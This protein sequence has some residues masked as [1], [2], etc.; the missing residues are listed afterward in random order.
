MLIQARINEDRMFNLCSWSA[1]AF[2]ADPML[3][4]QTDDLQLVK[5]LF[6][7]INKIEI[8]V[9]GN[10]AG[11]YTQYDTY[12]SLS[13]EGQVFVEHENVFADCMRVSLKR[14]SLADEVARI[15]EQV[16]PTIDVDA[17]TLEEYR[18][19]LLKQ[20]GGQCR[21]EIYAGTQVQLPSTGAIERYTYDDDDQR[22]LTNA[23]AILII[24]P[25]LPLI[26]YH[27]SGGFCRMIPSLD[28]LTIYGTLQVRLTYLTTRCNFMNMWIKSIQSKEALMDISWETELPQEY[29]EQV[30]TIY[31]QALQIMNAIREK[32]TP[33][34]NE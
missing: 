24:A 29:Q 34:E 18:T 2:D 6:S 26:P 21:Q 14:T 32:F 1:S 28:L 25:E 5:Q 20:I 10:P 31:S 19:Y 4:L 12:A 27:P 13:Y 30:D 16:S 7:K 33:N 17:M 8:Y 11:T 15:S 9:S 23:M 22:N 3:R